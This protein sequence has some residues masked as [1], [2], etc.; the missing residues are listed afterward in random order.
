M[1]T[2][3]TIYRKGTQRAGIIIL[4]FLL[5]GIL[6]AEELPHVIGSVFF[7]IEGKT[8]NL[9]LQEDLNL[10]PYAENFDS[11]EALLA[12]VE[13][14]KQYLFNK[15][16]FESVES[17]V[18]LEQTTEEYHVYTVEYSI[19]DATTFLPL[20]YGKFDSNYG[21]KIGLKLYDTNLFGTLSNLY[22]YAG[23][24]Q[25]DV[26][27]FDLFEI[28]STM[29]L[30]NLQ[31]F[32]QTFDLN[33]NFLINEENGVFSRGSYSGSINWGNIELFNQTI[34]VFSNISLIQFY[35][36]DISLWGNPNLNIGFNWRNISVADEK[37]D[38]YFNTNLQKDGISWNLPNLTF[39]TKL[40]SSTL[41]LFG[42]DIQT[43]LE[44]SITLSTEFNSLTS[45]KI[46]AG[47]TVSY[48]LTHDITYTLSGN[49]L[50]DN[51]NK[52][53]EHISFNTSNTFTH[54]RI[55]WVD[56]LREGDVTSLMISTAMPVSEG[57]YE[58]VDQFAIS[59]VLQST[60]F[61]LIGED[62]FNLSLRGV[63]YIAAGSPTYF[64]VVPGEYMRGILNRNL[65]SALGYAGLILNTNFTIKLFDF[66][67]SVFGRTPDGEFLI[68][69]F[70]DFSIFDS[71]PIIDTVEATWIK[72]SGGIE[73]YLIFDSF[74][75]YP[76]TVTAGVNLED[77]V[78]YFQKIKEFNRIEFEI[79]L[80]LS[81]FY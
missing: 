77:V 44:H 55:D 31:L 57:F 27:K 70:F 75:S 25:L 80:S 72:Y 8:N 56:N 58:L 1:G 66:T 50:T 17:S 61:S 2:T 49:I 54:G 71:T 28:T 79:I 14:R 63:G 9:V 3:S 19:I 35:D 65:P 11:K 10:I 7:N 42:K 21:L 78:D 4:L 46:N 39:L 16:I 52:L 43:N 32:N 26:M 69:P 51:T 34:D 53:F 67:L 12:R 33:M 6:Q 68:S 18:K 45:Q 37:F 36:A 24:R 40:S 76:F 60:Y 73:F 62:M 59:T 30:S 64:P 29:S 23:A 74:R 47:L 22:F 48:S 13:E 15:R 38:I 81:M 5:G 41:K 20:P